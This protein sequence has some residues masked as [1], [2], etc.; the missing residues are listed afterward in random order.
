MVQGGRKGSKRGIDGAGG[1]SRALLM[2]RKGPG[3]EERVQARHWWCRRTVD[4]REGSKRRVDGTGGV[5]KC[6]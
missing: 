5:P 3:R 4:G 2:G 6:C 1:R